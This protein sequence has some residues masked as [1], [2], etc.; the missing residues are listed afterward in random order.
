[1]LIRYELNS[2]S[3]M[4]M[5]KPVVPGMMTERWCRSAGCSVAYQVDLSLYQ[6]HISAFNTSMTDRGRYG[7]GVLRVEIERSDVVL[8]LNWWKY[9]VLIGDYWSM[10]QREN[11]ECYQ[12]QREIMHIGHAIMDCIRETEMMEIIPGL[13]VIYRKNLWGK[14][15]WKVSLSL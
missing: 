4:R 3:I 7:N 14:R 8:C 9:Y 6:F 13:W 1:M 11:G 2:L 15:Y 5:W 12:K 10:S